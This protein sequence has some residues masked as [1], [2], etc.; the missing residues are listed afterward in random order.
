[1]N[2]KLLFAFVVVAIVFES[3]HAMADFVDTNM[4]F[5]VKSNG[6]FGGHGFVHVKYP[7]NTNQVEV[8]LIFFFKGNGGSEGIASV[9]KDVSN[10]KVDA[11]ILCDGGGC[12]QLNKK[13]PRSGH[14]IIGFGR[15]VSVNG[16]VNFNFKY[17]EIHHAVAIAIKVEEE[18][19]IFPVKI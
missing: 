16:Y 18:Y 7:I 14:N 11:W 9:L 12:L 17:S 15:E 10:E 1:M 5:E 8:Q 6:A 3:V 13:L 19:R 4:L 2:I